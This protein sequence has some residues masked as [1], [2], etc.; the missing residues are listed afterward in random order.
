M[1]KRFSKDT[2]L[3]HIANKMQALE[4]QWGFDPNNG[5]AQVTNSEFNRIMAYGEYTA[6]DYLYDQ[7]A[8]GLVGGK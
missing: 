3:T 2:M 6:L 7:I 4:T 8:Y 1:K 5:N